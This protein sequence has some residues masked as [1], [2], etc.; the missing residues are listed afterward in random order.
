M[1]KFRKEGEKIQKKVEVE[2]LIYHPLSMG[3]SQPRKAAAPGESP[4]P[5]AR[6]GHRNSTASSASAERPNAGGLQKLRRP[7]GALDR[8]KNKVRNLVVSE[9]SPGNSSPCP[10]SPL[11]RAGRRMSESTLAL[12][13]VPQWSNIDLSVDR[14]SWR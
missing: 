12:L 8:S 1:V 11:Y 4:E 10:V 6:A 7:S 5:R 13:F 14:M 9:S 2:N 3:A